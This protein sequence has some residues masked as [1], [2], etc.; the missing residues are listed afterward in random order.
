MRVHLLQKT[1]MIYADDFVINAKKTGRSR[2]G[3]SRHER[4]ET[5][6]G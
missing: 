2:H 4:V 3:A 6:K 1:G 5:M